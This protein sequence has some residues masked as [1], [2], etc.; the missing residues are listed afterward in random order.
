MLIW[1]SSGRLTL[2]IASG[3]SRT[4]S[5]KKGS[6]VRIN[7][8]DLGWLVNVIG[9]ATIR[10]RAHNFLFSYCRTAWYLYHFRHVARYVFKVVNV[11]YC[12]CVWNLANWNFMKIF[13]HKS[14][15]PVYYVAS[16][17][18]QYVQLRWNTE[19]WRTDTQSCTQSCRGP[20]YKHQTQRRSEMKS[21]EYYNLCKITKVGY[22]AQCFWVISDNKLN[23]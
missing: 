16:Q 17:A 1:G 3:C 7:K 22:H 21:F 20:R 14:E 9:D 15:S 12:M 2:D 4:R 13:D 8:G 11:S 18:W 10:Y 6:K 23:D 19:M 5:M